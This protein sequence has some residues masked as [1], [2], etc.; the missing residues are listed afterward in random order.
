MNFNI[1]IYIYYKLSL[2]IAPGCYTQHHT[3][4]C[5]AKTGDHACLRLVRR[6]YEK[7]EE[8]QRQ[9]MQKHHSKINMTG[10]SQSSPFLLARISQ[11]EDAALETWNRLNK[12]KW[13]NMRK[14]E[15]K[16]QSGK[17]E[18]W[19]MERKSGAENHK[20]KSCPRTGAAPQQYIRPQ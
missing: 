15:N 19:K 1:Y 18:K 4:S 14:K 5:G 11:S 6:G 7:G 10:T 3:D 8:L 17:N 13:T 9:P 20:L 12:M 2:F 16:W